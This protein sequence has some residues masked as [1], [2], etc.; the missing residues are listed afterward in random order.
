MRA[1]EFEPPV[2]LPPATAPRPRGTPPLPRRSPRGSTRAARRSP[3]SKASALGPTVCQPPRSSSNWPAAF[4]GTPGARL[5]PGV[6]ELNGRDRP[7]CG[8]ETVDPRQRFD[9]RVVPQALHPAAKCVR[10]PVTAVASQITN[11]APPT[12]R[13][14]RW[15]KCQSF[16]MP[17]SEEYMHIGETPMRLRRVTSLSRNS[18]NRVWCRHR[19]NIR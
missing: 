13:E 19:G 11:P 8:D 1:V 18:L 3:S 17:S 12:A 15:T 10:P 9:L 5:A 16:A 4:P 7:V 6:C 2:T 14:P